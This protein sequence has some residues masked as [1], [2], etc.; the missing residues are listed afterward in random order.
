MYIDFHTHIFPDKI[1]EKTISL[2]L[3][4]LPPED[5]AYSDGT[6]NGLKNSMKESG[7]AYSVVQPVVTKPS[8]F[9]S[10]NAY[11]A[12]INGKDGIISFGG[13]H[14]DND[15]IENKLAYIKSL[16]LLGVKLHPD[17]Q[18]T[19][20]DDERYIRII[21][22]C[23]RIGLIIV[24]H[25][26]I[27]VGM[28][29][30]VHCP[31]DRA[32]RMINAVYGDTVPN[33]PLIVLAHLGGFGMADEVADKLVGKP[34][35]FDLAVTLN[36]YS[37]EQVMKVIRSHGAD[38]ILFA[39]DSPWGG[40]KEFIEIFEKLPLTHE[41]KELISHKNAEHLFALKH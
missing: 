20:I 36:R 14:P 38:R 26:G 13:I 18:Q 32:V 4:K 10:I 16:G 31:P 33:Q 21:K 30:V 5:K 34:V 17:Y 2:L 7:V 19:F 39:T 27:D 23:V 9:E 28:P 29:E 40:Q 15:D 35:Y 12:E 25:A 1:A 11:A 24:I 41:E 22:E 3:T 6:L 8:Q 37:T